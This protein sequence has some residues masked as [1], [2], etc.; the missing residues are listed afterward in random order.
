[1]WIN[2]I[3]ANKFF[4]ENKLFNNKFSDGHPLPEEQLKYMQLI[5][6][7]HKFKDSTILAVTEKQKTTIDIILK[8]VKTSKK[9]M[10]IYEFGADEK[11]IK[12]K[13]TLVSSI[14]DILL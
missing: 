8:K 3:Q 14:G 4:R 6:N 11:I 9:H 5:F 2:D 12:Q 10:A 1:L 13:S 7:N